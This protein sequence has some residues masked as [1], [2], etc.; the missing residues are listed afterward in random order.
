M[1]HTCPG[2][3]H[4]NRMTQNATHDFAP[5]EQGPQQQG[6]LAQPRRQ[7]TW[8][9]HTCGGLLLQLPRQPYITRASQVTV[10]GVDKDIVNDSDNDKHEEH[11]AR[12]G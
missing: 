6:E 9:L 1:I 7:P 2:Q 11:V 5:P 4:R 3:A 10:V 8:R 12:T